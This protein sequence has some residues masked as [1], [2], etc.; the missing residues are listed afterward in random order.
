GRDTIALM[1][2]LLQIINS[3][4]HHDFAPNLLALSVVQDDIGPHCTG[5]AEC[6]TRLLI[7]Q[8]GVNDIKRATG[9]RILQAS[10]PDDEGGKLNLPP[11]G[12]DVPGGRMECA[13]PPAL[14]GRSSTA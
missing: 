7:R 4:S 2:N 14:T 11:G 6:G 10:I 13:L 8:L 1:R 9:E 5:P 3:V 12:D